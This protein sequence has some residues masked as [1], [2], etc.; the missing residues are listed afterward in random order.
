MKNQIVVNPEFRVNPLSLTPGGSTVT[1]I[2]QDGKELVYSNVKNPQAYI[3]R[4]LKNNPDVK[5]FL[6]NG[7]PVDRV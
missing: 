5:G 6:V 7:K 3:D 4:V 2:E 1:V